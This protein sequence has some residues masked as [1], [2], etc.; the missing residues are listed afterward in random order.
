MTI[1]VAIMSYGYGHLVAHALESVLDQSSPPDRV[2]VVDDGVGDCRH[3]PKLYPR[4]EPGRHSEVEFEERA[5]NLGVVCNFQRVLFSVETDRLMMLGA[6]NWLSPR[7]LEL[8]NSSPSDIVSYDLFI[9]GDKAKDFAA[10]VG[11]RKLATQQYLWRWAEKDQKDLDSKN[12]IH[13]SALF[14]VRKARL[15]GG[16]RHS[17]NQHSEEDWIL[18]K[19]MIS[20]GASHTHLNF[21]LMYY[22]KHSHNFNGN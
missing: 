5:V 9:V 12:Y 4:I 2:L 13:G 10:H 20:S 3:I 1:T 16:Y 18:W 11:A 22:R 17:G 6:D 14:D 7:C 19:S 21:P 15:C 8:C